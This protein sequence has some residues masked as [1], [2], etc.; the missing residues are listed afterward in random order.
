M[1][2][3]AANLCPVPPSFRLVGAC[4]GRKEKARTYLP[5]KKGCGRPVVGWCQRGGHT[6]EQAPRVAQGN[7]R[8]RSNDSIP[9]INGTGGG[10]CVCGLRGALVCGLWDSVTALDERAGSRGE[11]GAW[12]PPSLLPSP[13]SPACGDPSSRQSR[14]AQT[15]SKAAVTS[16]KPVAASS[17]QPASMSLPDRR[18]G[19][20]QP[21]LA[22]HCPDAGSCPCITERLNRGSGAGQ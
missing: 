4:G 14:P 10:W 2:E 11:S 17:G 21:L 6:S 22:D 12:S 9:G 3:T 16:A 8:G 15:G 18:S 19:Q 5:G 20:A 1:R 13:T 7:G